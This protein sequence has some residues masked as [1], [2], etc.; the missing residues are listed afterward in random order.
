[1][2]VFTLPAAP[3]GKSICCHCPRGRTHLKLDDISFEQH[4]KD[5]LDD[6]V[7]YMATRS[8]LVFLNSK[9]IMMKFKL[10]FYFSIF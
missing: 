3:R 6:V 8:G 4:I 1:M 9:P 7:Y 5:A 10:K 2:S